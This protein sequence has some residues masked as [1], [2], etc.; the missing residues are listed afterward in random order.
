MAESFS[1]DIEGG[2][3]GGRKRERERERGKTAYA[4]FKIVYIYTYQ[5][6]EKCSKMLKNDIFEVSVGARSARGSARVVI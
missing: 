1:N 6:S 4:I 3:D 5:K 2:R